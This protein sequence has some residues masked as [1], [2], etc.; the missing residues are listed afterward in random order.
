MNV[1]CDID[2]VL[3]TGF[4][5]K[6]EDYVIVSGRTVDEWTRTVEEFGSTRPIY[7]RPFGQ[8]GD[9]VLAGRWKSVIVSGLKLTKFYEDDAL[10]AAIIKDTCPD[11]E[12]VLVEA[13]SAEP[14]SGP[15][16]A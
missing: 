13:S 11:C 1:G 5:P 9:R 4:R 8:P 16:I 2:G 14:N 7:L 15:A 6:E 10:Q 3:S 12:V